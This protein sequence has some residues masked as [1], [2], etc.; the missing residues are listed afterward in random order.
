MQ[1]RDEVK[2]ITFVVL[3]KER[4]VDHVIEEEGDPKSLNN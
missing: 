4:V 3:I 1:S 2:V